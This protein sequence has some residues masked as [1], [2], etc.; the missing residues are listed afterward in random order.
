MIVEIINSKVLANEAALT[1]IT[2]PTD[3]QRYWVTGVGGYVFKSMAISGHC[4]ADDETP[5][6]WCVDDRQ[7]SLVEA[8][9]VTVLTAGYTDITSAVNTDWFEP[10]RPQ[11]ISCFSNTSTSEVVVSTQFEFYD[12]THDTAE[13]DISRGFTH[14]NGESTLDSAVDAGYYDVTVRVHGTTHGGTNWDNIAYAI[15]KNDDITDAVPAVVVA[16]QTPQRRFGD[17]AFTTVWLDGGDTVSIKGSN[18]IRAQNFTPY[19]FE[20]DIRKAR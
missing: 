18:F 5:G 19:Y 13:Q 7:V 15:F 11:A 17:C 14:L 16:Y 3:R 9:F 8:R 4:Q 1:A 20:V 12:L 2:T 10:N 6:W